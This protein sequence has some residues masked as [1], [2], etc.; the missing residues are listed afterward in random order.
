M[1]Y[2][3]SHGSDSPVRRIDANI[4]VEP[5]D[6]RSAAGGIQRRS[7][8]LQQGVV[9]NRTHAAGPAPRVSILYEVWHT[10]A[11]QAMLNV[12]TG[13]GV[14]LTVVSALAS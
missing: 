2:E 10:P 13:G 14:P 7:V 1:L 11:A 4:T 3:V 12:S 6:L 5:A 9:L 8:T